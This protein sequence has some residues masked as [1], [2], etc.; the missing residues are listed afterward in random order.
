MLFT[1]GCAG[2]CCCVG[3]SLVAVWGLLIECTLLWST[4]SME[5]RLQQWWCMD[6]AVAAPG[7]LNT[8]SVLVVHR[9]SYSMACGIFSAQR[10]IACLLHWQ[11]DFF[12]F[13]HWVTRE[14]LLF[15][16]VWLC[17]VLVVTCRTFSR[18]IQDPL[19]TARS[20]SG[21]LICGMGTLSCSMWHLVSSPGME[22]RPSA[23]R[24]LNLSNGT[25]REVL[26]PWFRHQSQVQV[27]TLASDQQSV[28][29]DQFLW[30]PPEVW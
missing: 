23:L 2:L 18:G 13:Y 12:F 6:S 8:G 27:V 19:V 28:N 29:W 5:L 7:L 17:W 15:L 11:V 25:T 3:F 24:A 30:L 10:S 9:L 16:F 14:A 4:G 26:T 21:T 20:S 1:F 22:P